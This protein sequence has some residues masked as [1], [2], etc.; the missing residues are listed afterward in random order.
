M[1]LDCF[2][3][4]GGLG[5]CDDC[6]ICDGDN[7]NMDDCDVCFGNNLDM[8]CSGVCFGL[9]QEDDCGICD[10]VLDN[11][12]FFN[13]TSKKRLENYLIKV[14]DDSGLGVSIKN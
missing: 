12:S 13:F 8:D 3:V 9:F 1:D 4:S 11:D 6:G 2:G 7:I 14:K 10:D 5:E